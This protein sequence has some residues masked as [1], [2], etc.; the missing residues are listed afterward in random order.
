MFAACVSSF[1]GTWHGRF[2]TLASVP[3]LLGPLADFQTVSVY[4]IR[5]VHF[6][7]RLQHGGYALE[8]Q[9][10]EVSL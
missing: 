6:D 9:D 5:V 10:A 3:D 4:R 8:A 2:T 7:Q 1:S